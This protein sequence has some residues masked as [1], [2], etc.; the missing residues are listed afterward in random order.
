MS[1]DSA[2]A[3]SEWATDELDLIVGDYFTMLTAELTGEPYVKRRRGLAL[4][5]EIGRSHKSIEFKHM[6]ISAVL[7]ELG[8]PIIEGYKPKRNYQEAIFGAIDRYL[9]THPE[10]LT[11]QPSPVMVAGV[12]EDEDM[13]VQAPPSLLAA[14]SDNEVTTALHRIV[15]KFD[16]VERD[17]RNRALGRLGE[18]FIVELERGRLRQEG[19][20]DLSRRVRWVSQEDGDGAGY[21]ILSF[22]ARG[23]E[24]LLEVKTTNGG[25]R[26]P[27]FLT[28]NER[29]VSEERPDAFR[30]MRVFDYVRKPCVF[31]LPP[32]LEHSVVLTAENWRASFS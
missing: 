29:A 19:R 32:P 12:A 1:F 11:P 15:R 20:E 4:Q 31:E 27:F 18:A 22:S 5:A 3:G 16:P 8:L 10:V 7:A 14:P 13:Y 17:F 24:R 9:S 2:K 23:E 30:L 21:D 28:R 26:T 6:N 25:A